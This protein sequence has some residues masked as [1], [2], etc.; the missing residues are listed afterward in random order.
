MIKNYIQYDKTN[1]KV[2]DAEEIRKIESN[3]NESIA[4]FNIV[5]MSY[6]LE[7]EKLRSKYGPVLEAILSSIQT[8]KSKLE[9]LT[10]SE[11]TIDE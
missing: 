1:S 5:R 7:L 2:E 4:C 3:I 10:E 8:D 9:T 6:L 11:V